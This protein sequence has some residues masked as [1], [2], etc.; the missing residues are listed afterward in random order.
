MGVEYHAVALALVRDSPQIDSA[1]G[2][3][4]CGTHE[5]SPY[6]VL[7][8]NCCFEFRL[9]ECVGTQIAKYG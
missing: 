6:I 2:P 9:Q 5:K 4:V 3:T 1:F 7:R 8:L